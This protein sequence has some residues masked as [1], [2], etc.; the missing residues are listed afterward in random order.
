MQK[1]KDFIPLVLGII[2]IIFILID[3]GVTV[4]D[5]WEVAAM[6]LDSCQSIA[7]SSQKEILRLTA[8]KVI[9]EQV[10]KHPYHG[11]LNLIK[12]LY[13]FQGREW[14]SCIFYSIK[15]IKLHGNGIVNTYKHFSY[16]VLEKAVYNLSHIYLAKGNNELADS[17]LIVG[18]DNHRSS[19]LLNFARSEI[20]SKSGNIDSAL[21]YAIIAFNQNN[22]NKKSKAWLIK[23][24]FE[25]GKI[26]FQSKNYARAL[27]IYE[28]AATIIPN[29]SEIYYNIAI[30]AVALGQFQKSE[31]AIIKSLELNQNNTKAAKM[32]V[33][34]Y[35][36]LNKNDLAAKVINQYKLNSN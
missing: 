30:A 15:S 27:K 3:L 8:G 20:F 2:L 33:R 10:A 19:I 34:I 31:N 9:N 5:P 26:E 32:L 6:Q 23:L 7:D 12:S 13:H 21:H 35:K 16:E 29:D 24:L 11:R 36:H 14:D 17:V 4:R 28:N 1:I 25:K 18:I 22:S